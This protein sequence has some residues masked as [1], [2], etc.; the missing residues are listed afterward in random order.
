MKKYTIEAICKNDIEFNE[1][2]VADVVTSYEYNVND[3]ATGR[4]LMRFDYYIQ[5]VT[6]CRNND[7]AHAHL[8]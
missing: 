8:Y 1:D 3:A 4:P 7:E 2:G 6:Y 5:A